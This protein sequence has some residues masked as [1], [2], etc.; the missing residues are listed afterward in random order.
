MLCRLCKKCK[1][2]KVCE[3]AKR[4][5]EVLYCERSEQEIIQEIDNDEFLTF[6]DKIY[7][8]MNSAPCNDAVLQLADIKYCTDMGYAFDGINFF[9]A[10]LKRKW[11]ENKNS[12]YLHTL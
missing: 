9:I 6:I 8:E 3:E 10:Y 1:H 2:S 11:T 5:V 7:D 12:Q 4:E